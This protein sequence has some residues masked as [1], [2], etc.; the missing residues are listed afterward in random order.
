MH[1]KWTL[2]HT[3][4]GTLVKLVLTEDKLTVSWT[5][6]SYGDIAKAVVSART[7]ATAALTEL[8]AAL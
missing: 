3:T 6:R 5:V 8:K 2:T 4:S 1:E 7:G